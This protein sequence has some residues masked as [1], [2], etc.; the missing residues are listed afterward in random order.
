[1]RDNILAIR[2]NLGIPKNKT[3]EEVLEYYDIMINFLKLDE[4]DVVL[5]QRTQQQKRE[6]FY[7]ERYIKILNKIKETLNNAKINS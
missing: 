1:M 2:K 6:K 5:T 7:I 3:T 4:L